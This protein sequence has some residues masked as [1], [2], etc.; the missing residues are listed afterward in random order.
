MWVVI[1]GGMSVLLIAAI[2]N[3][4]RNTCKDYSIVIKGGES[5]DYFLNKSDV[6]SLLKAATG[7]DIKGQPKASFNLQQMESL[8]ESNVW[9]RDAQLYFDNKD[10]LHIAVTER[11]PVAR[12]FTNSGKSFYID[13]EEQGIPLSANMSVKLPVFTGVPDKKDRAKKDSL[14]MH[15]IKLVAQFIN[16]HPFWSLQVTQVDLVSYGTGGQLEFELVPLIGNH[17]IKLGTAGDLERKF[18]RLYTFYKQVLAKTGFDKYKTID[19]RFAGQV[20]GGKSENPK[21]DSI[22]LRKSVDELLKQIRKAEEE[23]EAMGMT[24]NTVGAGVHE[25]KQ[26]NATTPLSN[27]VMNGATAS[28]DNK[29]TPKAIMPPASTNGSAKRE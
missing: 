21:V 17:V 4:K 16:A 23:A 15:D 19:V 22:Q 20:V 11:K 7:G 2:G 8:L 5:K 9:I 29:A 28:K 6:A 26:V 27:D 25:T 14:L 18:A 1:A 3:Q 24:V 12:I 13:E 10:V